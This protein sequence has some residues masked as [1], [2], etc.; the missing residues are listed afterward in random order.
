MVSYGIIVTN[1]HVQCLNFPTSSISTWKPSCGSI[2]NEVNLPSCDGS[3][4]GLY[5]T[6]RIDGKD[7]PP[8]KQSAE[9]SSQE[10]S[11]NESS[12]MLEPP[13]C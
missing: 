11:N 9:Q 13:R 3:R 4:G 2:G 12:K 8:E 10:R 6:S 7:I 5:S 1:L